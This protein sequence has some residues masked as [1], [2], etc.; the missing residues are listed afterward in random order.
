MF[1]RGTDQIVAGT[2]RTI[3]VDQEFRHQ[4]QRDALQSGRRIRQ[5]GQDQMDDVFGNVVLTPGDEDLGAGDAEGA[6]GGARGLGADRR[7]VGAG[8]RLGQ[9]HG[10]GPGAFDHLRQV[11]LLEFVGGV[12]GNRLDGAAGQHRAQSEGHVGRLPH[13]IDRHG[14]RCRQPLPTV[15]RRERHGI[16]AGFAEQLVGLL[17]ARRG[18]DHA[19]L[20]HRALLVAIAV[21]RIEHTSRKLGGL[22]EDGFDQFDRTF[23]VTRQSADLVQT[24]DFLENKLHITQRGGV[25]THAQLP[26]RLGDTRIRVPETPPEWSRFIIFG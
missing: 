4:E 24:G 11:L 12:V 8:V 7:E 2:Q 18:G 9:V 1:E 26:F 17:E 22:F 3:V 13:F 6:I 10:A 15:F 25:S 23:L 5:T 21:D 20:D 16:P 14:H 19:I